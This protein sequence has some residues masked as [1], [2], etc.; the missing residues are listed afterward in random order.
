V[1][2]A[3]RLVERT[4]AA[5]ASSNRA[6]TWA[7]A[8]AAAAALIFALGSVI[9]NLALRS[10]LADTAR[11]V[12]ALEGRVTAERAAYEH[13][14][15][16]VADLAANDAVRAPIPYGTLVRH[17]PRLY[18]AFGALPALPR[19]HVYEAWTLPR[20]A[21]ELAPSITFAPSPSGTTLVPISENAAHLSAVGLSVE[22]D[23]GSR[24]PTTKPLF[25]QPLS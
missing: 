12:T 23:G 10:D 17:G 20:G 4:P 21:S 11:R 19:G 13:A 25:V 7:T 3:A 5:R 24:T 6:A 18:L 15:Q 14:E 1:D 8:I 22:P 16:I 9:Q 2:P